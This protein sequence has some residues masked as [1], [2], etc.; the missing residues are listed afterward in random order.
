MNQIVKLSSVCDN[1]KIQ[2]MNSQGY[3]CVQVFTD[4]ADWYGL[5]VIKQN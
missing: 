1:L 4:G 2:E 5:F 3:I